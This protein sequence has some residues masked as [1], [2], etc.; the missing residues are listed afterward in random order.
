[1]ALT[2]TLKAVL[3]S[4]REPVVHAGVKPASL[5]HYLVE[6]GA[7][8]E[9]L[10]KDTDIT[11]DEL[12]ITSNSYLRASQYYQLVE[13]A[14]ELFGKDILLRY[15][16]QLQYGYYSVGGAL[17][18]NVETLR[19]SLSM[20]VK[21]Q[22]ILSDPSSMEVI[23]NLNGSCDLQILV[24]TNCPK[25][26][27]NAFME[28]AMAGISNIVNTLFNLPSD[29]AS[30]YFDFPAPTHVID[31]KK[32]IKGVCCF[33]ADLPMVRFPAELLDKKIP[34]SSQIMKALAQQ[35]CEEKT[36]QVENY[37]GVGYRVGKIIIANIDD[38]PSLDDMA[39]RLGMS[40]STLKRHLSEEDLSYTKLINE[41]R[42]EYAIYY[43]IHE[44]KT[45]A[46]VSDALN[47]PG[48]SN[49]HKAFKRWTGVSVHD[50]KEQHNF[51]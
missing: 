46:E 21:Y 27:S 20:L 14:M 16:S 13:N 10:L 51:R 40:S 8:P 25:S 31:Y 44:G 39:A 1:M 5:F 12:K 26:V 38:I 23:E 3:H 34:N 29:V 22:D 42:K 48:A 18:A 36:E 11:I 28:S 30:Y 49:F 41:I 2:N 19:D 9:K 33:D 47:I 6:N 15:G 35:A 7:S 50:Y 4:I 37:Y 17:L 32:Y 24:P 43:L 45:V